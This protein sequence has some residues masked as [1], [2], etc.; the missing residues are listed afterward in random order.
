[1]T[2]HEFSYVDVAV[3]GAERR[4][5]VT[6]YPG[7]VTKKIRVGSIDAYLSVFRF[8][9]EYRH[10]AEAQGGSVKGYRGAAFADFLPFDIDYEGNLLAA[11]GGAVELLQHLE[12]AY[13]IDPSQVRVYF[14]GSKGFHLL[15]PTWLMGSVQGSEHLPAVFKRM[16]VTIAEG[17]GVPIAKKGQGGIDAVI[18][19]VNRILRFPDTVNSKSRLYKV[20]ML[21]DE[22]RTWTADE[23]RDFAREPRGKRWAPSHEEPSDAL[24]ELYAKLA[25]AVE[26]GAR[27]RPARGTA[28]GDNAAFV[29]A[30]SGA[31]QQGQ[32]HHL[33]L[34]F[35]GYAAKRHM[36]RERALAIIDALPSND[37]AGRAKDVDDTYDAVAAGATVRGYTDLVQMM[38]DADLAALREALGDV[39]KERGKED[40]GMQAK[41][42]E[43]KQSGM[44][45][46]GMVDVV[47]LFEEMRA[48]K[49]A[50]ITAVPTML[51]LWNRVCGEAGGHIGLAKGWYVIVGAKSGSGKSM[52][53][54]NLLST[55]IAGEPSRYT[56]AFMGGGE[57][58][59][60]ISLEMDPVANLSR[61]LPMMSQLPVRHFAHG[62]DFCEETFDIAVRAYQAH[63]ERTGGAL[64]TNRRM[65]S[66][67]EHITDAVRELYE[68]HGV[69]FHCVD[70][71]QLVELTAAGDRQRE[72]QMVK[73]I[74]NQLMF[75][76]A[77]L[78]VTIVA[79]SQLTREGSKE[80]DNPPIA[81]NLYGGSG[82]ENNCQQVALVDHTNF[83]RNGDSIYSTLVI[84]KNRVGP[85][86]VRVKY[87]MDAE[88]LRI[89]PRLDNEE[90]PREK[91][92]REKGREF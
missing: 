54:G 40:R 17:A 43:V 81:Q 35:S 78:K 80:R 12:D 44:E 37:P 38:D 79:A 8:P 88:S 71:M 67:L 25:E 21:A 11:R 73:E 24:V 14:S 26:S 46:I 86:G 48:E 9:E 85:P 36:P 87:T 5:N 2:E 77:E 23:I 19:D 49:K 56:D 39:P 7:D 65:V 47:T 82:M 10:H 51:R 64:Y 13:G 4:N 58:C 52:M 92:A 91:A 72:D 31:W 41:A 66:K 33:T 59:S 50:P 74:S 68:K 42:Q 18:Y 57:K 75:L 70:Y 22:L 1:M 15:V 84:D 28:E 30:L 60:L 34:A 3:G 62:P 83:H 89:R 76:A 69:G 53:I 90:T 55:A 27:D 29:D 45:T 61:I 32:K 63:V 6:H 16:A 20:E